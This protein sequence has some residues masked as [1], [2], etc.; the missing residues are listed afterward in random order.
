MCMYVSY[1]L[2]R[3]NIHLVYVPARAIWCFAWGPAI[4]TTPAVTRSLLSTVYCLLSTVY[5]LSPIPPPGHDMLHVVNLSPISLIYIYRFRMSTARRFSLK[6]ARDT[7]A[8]ALFLRSLGQGRFK[9]YSRGRL[10]LFLAVTRIRTPNFRH[11]STTSSS[12]ARCIPCML[13]C[14]RAIVILPTVAIDT[15]VIPSNAYCS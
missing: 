10:L 9:Y 8:R 4:W 11:R 7:P 2:F 6:F 12:I 14:G 13:V 5:W 1:W 15:V 3:F